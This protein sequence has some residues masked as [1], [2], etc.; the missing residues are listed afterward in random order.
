M[1]EK[2]Y[3]E[4]IE[5][6][7]IERASRSAF[8]VSTL[9]EAELSTLIQKLNIWKTKEKVI[10][11]EKRFVSL[12]ETDLDSADE[13]ILRAL[14]LTVPAE[15]ITNFKIINKVNYYFVLQKRDFLR[16]TENHFR[17]LSTLAEQEDLHNPVYVRLDENGA[18]VFD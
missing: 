7:N 9:S 13:E 3:Q 1:A 12:S 4:K 5:K 6:I 2:T 16:L 10:M 8:T 17:V 15:N 11:Q 18:L 14:E